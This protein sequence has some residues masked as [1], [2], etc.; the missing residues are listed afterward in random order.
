MGDRRRATESIGQPMWGRNGALR[1]VSDRIGVVAD[2]FGH[3]GDATGGAAGRP[4]PTGRPR[5]HGPDWVLSQMTMAE[6]PGGA[7]VARMTGARPGRARPTST[8]RSRRPRSTRPWCWISPAYRSR[9]SAL[10]GKGSPSSGRPPMPHP[11]C[12]CSRQTAGAG[13]AGARSVQSPPSAS[14]P[15]TATAEPFSLTGRSGRPVY[16]SLYRPAR[17]GTTGPSG[18][19]PPLVVWCHGGPTAAAGAGFDLALQFFTTR[20]FAVACV[21]YAGSTGYGR[22][23][24]M[25]LWG[26]GRGL[27]PRIAGRPPGIWRNGATWI[28]AAWP[29]GA[30]APVG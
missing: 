30:G 7:L 10:T 23:H 13:P 5:L 28:R 29:S 20:G 17:K 27:T 25:A 8:R 14:S 2:V 19:R 11:M 22:P 16:G 9:A 21:D 1:F 6:L 26:Q 24:R 18:Q 12:G 15:R 4:R 3:P